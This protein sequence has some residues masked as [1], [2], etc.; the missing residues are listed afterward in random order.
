MRLTRNRGSRSSRRERFSRVYPWRLVSGRKIVASQRGRRIHASIGRSSAHPGCRIEP[1]PF[2]GFGRAIASG[3]SCHSVPAVSERVSSKSEFNLDMTRS[4][5]YCTN[6]GLP[7]GSTHAG[8]GAP[9]R[10]PSHTKRVAGID[11]SILAICAESVSPGSP[12][13]VM[14]T[15]VVGAESSARQDARARASARFVPPRE[16]VVLSRPRTNE[17]SV[18]VSRDCGLMSIASQANTAIHCS[19]QWYA[20]IVSK[21]SLLARSRR[22]SSDH[23]ET[24]W[25][26]MLFE[27]STIQRIDRSSVLAHPN[28]KTIGEI[29][30][31]RK[32]PEDTPSPTRTRRCRG[33]TV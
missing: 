23:R 25:A 22:D 5:R 2:L 3:F 31:A 20:V 17:R 33:K 11:P 27:T 4:P 13:S 15:T 10:E 1:V 28:P 21:M 18:S 8:I 32:I 16:T 9:S 19:L 24:S 14:I 30:A 6:S 26:S 7:N 12:P 29:I